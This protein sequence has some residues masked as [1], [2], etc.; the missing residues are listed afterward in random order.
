MVKNYI[1]QSSILGEMS[2][3]IAYCKSKNKILPHILL[4]GPRGLGKTY[5]AKTIA[6]SIGAKC[7]TCL[8]NQ[9]TERQ[10]QGILI[11]SKKGEII[12]MDE[13][14]SLSAS[15]AEYLYTPMQDFIINYEGNK[16]TFEVK[17]KPFT[18]IGATTEPGKILKPLFD[19]FIYNLSMQ[20]YSQEEIK[21]IVRSKS[22][23]K[24]D[25]DALD[26]ICNMS[27]RNPR[28]AIALLTGCEYISG[29]K[30]TLKA[31]E[32][33]R[34]GREM[35]KDGLTRDQM[36]YLKILKTAT[37]PM[38]KD[39]MSYLLSKS[40]DYIQSSMEP[41]LLQMELIQR[42]PR[43]RTISVLGLRYLNEQEQ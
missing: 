24:L 34:I 11:N 21:E 28:R 1:G 15:V 30:I 35:T 42:T 32:E 25:E 36:E 41:D 7:H 31:V 38:G 40:P 39:A 33:L 10:L 9:A 5:L 16:K 23:I 20:R 37:G 43:G 19:R 18:V 22:K 8:G 6:E 3:V 17:V 26:L 13:I 27:R 29:G 14:H 12:I 2:K 4:H